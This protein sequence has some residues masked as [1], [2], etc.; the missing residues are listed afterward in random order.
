MHVSIRDAKAHLSEYIRR[1]EAGEEVVLTS[2]GRPVVRLVPVASTTTE[3][4]PETAA[5]ARLR[6]LPIVSRGDDRSLAGGI[7]PLFRVAE[8]EKS[9]AEIVI[10]DRGSRIEDRG[11][12]IG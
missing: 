9:L 1:A 8:G 5:I 6:A 2:H 7:K 11:C 12:G 4:D 10:E 3:E